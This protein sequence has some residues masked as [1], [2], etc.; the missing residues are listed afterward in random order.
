M[1]L[2]DRCWLYLAVTKLF[3]GGVALIA[4]QLRPTRAEDRL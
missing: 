3:H 4:F 1:R 2:R